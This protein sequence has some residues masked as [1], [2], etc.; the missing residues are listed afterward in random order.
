M[1]ALNA[2]LTL[3]VELGHLLVLQGTTAVVAKQRESSP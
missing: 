2:R 3:W 1:L